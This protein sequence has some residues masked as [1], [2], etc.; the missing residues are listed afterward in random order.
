M[1]C[2]K[3]R[4]LVVLLALLICLL[5]GCTLTRY[6][7]EA[8]VQD[9]IKQL[10]EEF[11][12][13]DLG[14]F[15]VQITD[16][17]KVEDGGEVIRVTASAS[18]EF[19]ELRVSCELYYILA[20]GQW[21]MDY[22]YISGYHYTLLASGVTEEDAQ[23]VLQD[24]YAKNYESLTYQDRSTDLNNGTDMF[25]YEGVYQDGYLVMNDWLRVCDQFTPESGWLLTGVE[26]EETSRSWDVLG[27]W[28][29]Q[30]EMSEMEITIHE[31][32]SEAIQMEYQFDFCYTA[33]YEGDYVMP[34]RMAFASDGIESRSFQEIEDG[35]EF[36]VGNDDNQI[37]VF[38]TAHG[39][40]ALGTEGTEE[41][42]SFVLQY[43]HGDNYSMRD[44][45]GLWPETIELYDYP[46]VYTSGPD[47]M[48][49][50]SR[51]H[52][53]TGLHQN[54][55]ADH[56][57]TSYIHSFSYIQDDGEDPQY[58]SNTYELYGLYSILTGTVYLDEDVDFGS[59]AVCRIY[60]D[61]NLLYSKDASTFTEE[62]CYE[63]LSIDVTGVRELTIECSGESETFY[64]VWGP[65]ES[66]VIALADLVVSR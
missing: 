22:C 47:G 4:Y 40:V 25:T 57:E 43:E 54:A 46:P 14:E 8:V 55:G 61:G 44:A 66:P 65:F 34:D 33:S 16:R 27:S 21:S 35:V 31:I 45:D 28:T 64:S 62:N 41:K 49:W 18:N 32:T 3:K 6:S 60:G 26:K 36:C 7:K 5:A 19:L 52:I 48:T 30:N 12:A 50:I 11:G 53:V 51:T 10:Q 59:S 56:D 58:A 20:G 9:V 2:L 37:T 13:W 29:Y 42:S 39:G 24:T 15:S 38:L 63:S 23:S 1:T 17:E